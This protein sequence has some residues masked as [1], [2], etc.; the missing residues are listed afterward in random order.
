MNI[1]L[2]IVLAAAALGL[3]FALAA[4]WACARSLRGLRAQCN[5]LRGALADKDAVLGRL[6]ARCRAL[7]G[8]LDALHDKLGQDETRIEQLRDLVKV[9]VARRLELDAWVRPIQSSLGEAFGHMLRELKEQ[10]ARQESAL[11]RHERSVAEAEAQHRGRH[12]ELERLRLE[13]ALKNYHIAALNE[14]FIRVEERMQDLTAQV[15]AVRLARPRA[16]ESRSDPAPPA[17]TVAVVPVTGRMHSGKAARRDWMEMLDEWHQQLHAQID[18]MD[19][20]QAQL[21][22][23]SARADDGRPSGVRT[24]EAGYG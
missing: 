21:R 8:E 2:E 5:R 22:P 17:S 11:S 24:G 18:R 7:E 6:L 3:A 13:L 16:D 9:H 15:A 10:L 14:R 1:D 12:E 20:L 23:G 19:A 4:G